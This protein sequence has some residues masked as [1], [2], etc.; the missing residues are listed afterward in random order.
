MKNVTSKKWLLYFVLGLFVISSGLILG[1]MTKSSSQQPVGHRLQWWLSA[2]NWDTTRTKETGKGVLVAILDSGVDANHPDLK[3]KIA[4]EY[5]VEGLKSDNAKHVL[6]GTAVAGILAG[7]PSHEKGILGV[8]ENVQILSVDVTDQKNGAIEVDNLVEG[9]E[10]AISQKADILC[11]S[12]GVKKD[13]K[14]LKQVIEK[15]YDAGI[16]IV[17]A[18]GNY[19]ENDMLYPAKYKEVLAVGALSK[20]K[21]IIS[22]KGKL[23][24]K[25]I[26]LP[27]ENIVTA[28][29]NGGYTGISGTSAATPILSGI[30]ALMMERNKQLTNDKIMNYFNSYTLD[31]MDVKKCIRLK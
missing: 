13:S 2:I 7:S 24:K 22:P 8:A 23:D 12:A 21:N 26:Y 6:H 3:G 14:K 11:I 18:S 29:S 4:S 15:A 27:G 25:V 17:A 30:V 10:Y 20:E 28:G 5:R 1:R 31:S 19:M 9:I 16:V